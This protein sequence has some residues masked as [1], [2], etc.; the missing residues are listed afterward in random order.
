[1]ALDWL[2]VIACNGRRMISLLFHPALGVPERLGPAPWFRITGNFIRQGPDGKVIA[3]FH[4]CTWKTGGRNYT[5]Y[6]VEGSATIRF[7]DGLG[8]QSDVFGP[9][10]LIKTT[11]RLTWTNSELFAKFINVTQLWHDIKHDT[12]WPVMVIARRKPHF[13]LTA[14]F[15]SI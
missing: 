3:T 4:N 12:Y 14:L 6:D 11:D 13:D 1:M 5:A 9:F 15:R 10:D 2:R 8:G 7:E